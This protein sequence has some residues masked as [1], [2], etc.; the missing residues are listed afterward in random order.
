MPTK[1]ATTLAKH[2]TDLVSA[3]RADSAAAVSG[4]TKR[5]AALGITP[6]GN[7]ALVL[8]DLCLL[9]LAAAADATKKDE[10]YAADKLSHKTPM[11]DRSADVVAIHAGIAGL[12]AALRSTYGEKAVASAF[13][14]GGAP[15][16]PDLLE[17]HARQ[18]ADQLAGAKWTPLPHAVMSIDVASAAKKL[19]TLADDLKKHLVE[20]SVDGKG[21][22]VDKS[23]RDDALTVLHDALLGLKDAAAGV[24]ALA[25][26]PALADT[27]TGHHHVAHP[28]GATPPAAPDGKMPVPAKPLP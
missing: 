11:D 15:K 14:T 10:A 1:H 12:H 23:G 19:V 4:L 7:V 17:K 26:E 27:L 20:V 16:Q 18:V 25:G 28:H 8:E 3:V 22:S 9:T 6:K 13:P 24:L 21:S 5:Y 2:A